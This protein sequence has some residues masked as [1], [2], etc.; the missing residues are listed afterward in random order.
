MCRRFAD[1]MKGQPSP[2]THTHA[3]YTRN[4][5]TLLLKA[6]FKR[7][8]GDP[9]TPRTVIPA[10][11]KNKIYSSPTGVNKLTIAQTNATT[12]VPY[13]AKDNDIIILY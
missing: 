3:T 12:T 1:G 11:K 13:H 8:G 5:N 4:N 7:K 10:V 9:P 2:L 6:V